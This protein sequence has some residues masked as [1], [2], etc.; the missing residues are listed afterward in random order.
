MHL[1]FANEKLWNINHYYT[2][3]WTDLELSTLYFKKVDQDDRHL[4]KRF[5]SMTYLL[6][7]YVLQ[8]IVNGVVLCM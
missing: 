7:K 2:N 5:C 8:K 3:A 6:D 4:W 1:W